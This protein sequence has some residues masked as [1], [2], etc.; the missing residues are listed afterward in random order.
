M[1]QGP[2][3]RLPLDTPPAWSESRALP[4]DALG[5]TAEG[6]QKTEPSGPTSVEALR[7]AVVAKLKSIYDPEIPVNL[8]DLG[9]IYAIEINEAHELRIAMTLTAPA[10]PVAA[11]LVKEVAEKTAEV[12]GIQKSEVDVVWDPP[13]TKDRMTEAAKLELGLF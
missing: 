2:K 3:K 1:E 5:H 8:Y 6:V 7:E 10:C 9:L 12:A 4:S 13:W 11:S